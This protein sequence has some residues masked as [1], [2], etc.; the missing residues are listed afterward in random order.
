MPWLRG[1]RGSADSWH[2]EDRKN[3]NSLVLSEERMGE[4]TPHNFRRTSAT[5]L[6]QLG[7]SLDLIQR[8]KTICLAGGVFVEP[9]GIRATQPRCVRL[10]GV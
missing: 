4:C 10:G 5:M 8:T 2:T 6:Q 1:S 3:D 7:V 9:V